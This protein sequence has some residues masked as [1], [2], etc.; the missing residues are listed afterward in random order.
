[1]KT[2]HK[3]YI[4]C[5]VSV[6]ENTLIRCAREVVSQGSEPRYW[7][8][9]RPYSDEDLKTSNAFVLILPNNQFEARITNLPSG[10]KKELMQAHMLGIPIYL[11]YQLKTTKEIKIFDTTLTDLTIKGVQG[12]SRQLQI[13]IDEYS[14]IHKVVKEIN[15]GAQFIESS[16]NYWI[17]PTEKE[18]F[19]NLFELG[20]DVV[21]NA[22]LETYTG[23]SPDKRLLLSL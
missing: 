20:V 7:E 6:E 5:P 1:M 21:G 2:N 14:K 4:S 19:N 3:T 17:H 8:R 9:G 11:A 13:D 10:C 18:V 15:T 12:T 22:Y 23:G 16:L